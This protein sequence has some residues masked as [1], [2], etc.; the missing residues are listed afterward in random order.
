MRKI[1]KSKILA[2]ASVMLLSAS[3]FLVINFPGV[4]FGQ[5]EILDN[6]QADQVDSNGVPVESQGADTSRI[7]AILGEINQTRNDAIVKLEEYI[8]KYQDADPDGRMRLML[9]GLYKEEAVEVYGRQFE[10]Y[11]QGII[12]EPPV[13]D[14]DPSIRLYRALIEEFPEGKTTD[15]ILYH[16]G[17]CLAASGDRE[18][19]VDLWTSLGLNY[20]ESEYA[21]ECWMRAGEILF[22]DYLF[23]E[24]AV[25]YRNVLGYWDSIY[26]DKALYKL[27]WV[28][29]LIDEY[30]EAISY[31]V[32]LLNDS[33]NAGEQAGGT[34]GEKDRLGL[35]KEA[36]EYA[37]LS[38]IEHGGVETF[39]AFNENAGEHS[40]LPTIL[41]QMG[42]YYEKRGWYE[43]AI[44]AYDSHAE[45]YP[46]HLSGPKVRLSS[47]RAHE[48]IEDF[49]GSMSSREALAFQFGAGSE[50]ALVNSEHKEAEGMSQFA[51][52][53]LYDAARFFHREGKQSGDEGTCLRAINDYQVLLEAYPDFDQSVEAVYAMAD[54]YFT[55]EMFDDAGEQYMTVAGTASE[56]DSLRSKAALNGIVSAEKHLESVPAEEDS[57]ARGVLMENCCYFLAEFP[58]SPKNPLVRY[59]RGELYFAAGE[60]DSAGVDFIVVKENEDRELSSKAVRMLA[61]SRYQVEDYTG[62]ET[63]FRH[64]A[65]FSSGET[66]TEME[67]MA[68][69]SLYKRADAL[70]TTD[71]LEEAAEIFEKIAIVQTDRV[72]AVEALFEAASLFS[73]VAESLVVSNPDSAASLNGRAAVTF[74]RLASI[75]PSSEL[76]P[77]A[78]YNAA[79]IR[80]KRED[81]L[82]ASKNYRNLSKNYPGSEYADE[83]AFLY[84]LNLEKGGAGEEAFQTY[85]VYAKTRLDP[86]RRLS[87]YLKMVDGFLERGKPSK[88]NYYVIQTYKLKNECE[89]TG[90]ELDQ[91][92]LSEIFFSGAEIT[93]K[94]FE[95][96]ELKQPLE[97]NLKKKQ[98]LLNTV[99]RE[100]LETAG[101]K[102]APWTFASTYRMGEAF[103]HYYNSLLNAELPAGL[104]AVEL[105]IYIIELEDAAEP[106]ID[107]AVQA[108]SAVCRQSAELGIESE[109]PGKALIRLEFLDP[110]AHDNI[111][112]FMGSSS[113][114]G[115][116][117]GENLPGGESVDDQLASLAPEGNSGSIE[118]A[119][120]SIPDHVDESEAM[121]LKKVPH[122]DSVRPPFPEILRQH[123]R[124]FL[125]GG[126]GAAG[127]SVAAFTV[128]DNGT[129]LGISSGVI[130]ALFLGT[131]SYFNFVE[132]ENGN[133]GTSASSPGR[134]F[135][136]VDR[137]PGVWNG[138]PGL[139]FRIYFR[140]L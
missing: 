139:G 4:V 121:D 110:S 111:Q 8:G 47:I 84:A 50:W 87:S 107:K 7:D 88:A 3:C 42:Q 93:Y 54:C 109:W 99:I 92:T 60:F 127:V 31:F 33:E 19:A 48:Q 66:R 131:W 94:R 56:S 126:V 123:E 40:Y 51:A 6:A 100:C 116:D 75:H 79:L 119:L 105:D 9:A 81:F 12:V 133:M 135:N 63:W 80:E 134:D 32:F 35:E 24:A 64:A 67:N 28:S 41:E 124:K 103:E 45:L 69:V 106:Y 129:A 125:Y 52:G 137:G 86:H 1:G 62:A 13:V 82:Q 29:Y 108:Y 55:V 34:A 30:D 78:F 97:K 61:R 91:A 38:F 130:S 120:E 122:S 73:T 140:G 46:L 77:K 18:T 95:E 10:L 101:L 76:A 43:A 132:N 27:G 102:V 136:V 118:E 2:N 26:F 113:S 37:A 104:S 89:G 70:K 15:R 85:R 20:P 44:E 68:L 74:E 23:D 21:A 90:V 138:K 71:Q 114:S 117:E 49:E 14:Y 36:L 65:E 16:L 112:A 98:R 59:K 58:E 25:A 83:A 5:Q 115:V 128:M 11:D 17:Y 39:N 96:V 22:D 53:S 72:G 57:L